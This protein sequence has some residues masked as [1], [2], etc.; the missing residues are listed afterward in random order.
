M[1]VC[2]FFVFFFSSAIYF[3]IPS[4]FPWTV[5]RGHEKVSPLSFN[6]VVNEFPS[7]V[8]DGMLIRA[9]VPVFTHY[10]SLETGREK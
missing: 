1:C 4:R 7:L 2:V 6:T 9:V 8:I 3:L 10:Q 5:Y